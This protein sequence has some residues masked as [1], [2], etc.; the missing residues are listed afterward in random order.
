MKKIILILAIALAMAN[1][2]ALLLGDEPTGELDSQTAAEVL[3][4]FQKKQCRF[5]FLM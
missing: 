1:Q 5:L 3:L 2:P 4:L